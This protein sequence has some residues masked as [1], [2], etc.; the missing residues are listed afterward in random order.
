MR[1]AY[2]PDWVRSNH[3]DEFNRPTWH[4][5]TAAYVPPYSNL[6]ASDLPDSEPN[7]VTQISASLAKL[8]CGQPAERAIYLCWVLHLVGD[9]HQPLHCCSQMTELFPDGDQGG[10]LAMVRINGGMPVRLHFAWDGMLGDELEIGSILDTVAELQQFEK[11]HAA[12]IAPA[13]ERHRTSAGWAVESFDLAKT[14]VYL[15]G[16][17]RPVHAEQPF[18]LALVPNLSDAYL[19]QAVPVARAGAVKAAC[20]LASNVSANLR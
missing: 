19:Q 5:V 3:A 14:H 12:S 2:W 13:I 9:I 11:A 7:V 18:D 17:L 15:N 1:A 4:Y 20:R 10:N 8:K 6:K 16:D